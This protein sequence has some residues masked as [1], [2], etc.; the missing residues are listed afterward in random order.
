MFGVERACVGAGQFEEACIGCRCIYHVV[1]V[2][3][4]DIV[5]HE[6][7]YDRGAQKVHI[8]GCHDR[9]LKPRLHFCLKGCIE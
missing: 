2:V 9:G 8:H 7:V 5:Q 4:E 3:L 6:G 1:I